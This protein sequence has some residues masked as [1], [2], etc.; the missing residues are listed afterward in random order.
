[1]FFPASRHSSFGVVIIA[2]YGI[3]LIFTAQHPWV[4]EIRACKYRRNSSV[5]FPSTFFVLNP[6]KAVA[7]HPYPSANTLDKMNCAVRNDT[8]TQ[9][10]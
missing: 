3:F 4:R 6:T 8:T 5:L 10:N 2:R 7:L 1:M 9:T